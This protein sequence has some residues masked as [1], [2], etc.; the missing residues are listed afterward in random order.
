MTEQRRG[1]H[2]FLV[3]RPQCCILPD[4]EAEEFSAFAV[5]PNRKFLPQKCV[6]SSISSRSVSVLN[7]SGTPS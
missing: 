4:W 6:A 5:Y 2:F 3:A 7:L 1:P